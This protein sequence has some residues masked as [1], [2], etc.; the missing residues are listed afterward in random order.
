MEYLVEALVS[1]LP[2]VGE[3]FGMRIDAMSRLAGAHWSLV[4]G[5]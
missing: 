3:T 5:P 4:M 2:V 1:S